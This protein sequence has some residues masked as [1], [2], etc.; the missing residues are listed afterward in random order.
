MNKAYFE[1]KLIDLKS[2]LTAHTANINAINGAIQLCNIVISDIEAE[3]KSEAL[4]GNS[5]EQPDV[6]I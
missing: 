2:Q 1:G 4:N 5:E 3:E 6:G